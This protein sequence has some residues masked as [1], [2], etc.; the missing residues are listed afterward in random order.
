[1]VRLA[2]FGDVFAAISDPT[3]RE[4]LDRLGGGD[5]TVS[6]LA[7][8]FE[9]SQPAV[10]QH[11]RILRQAG[12]VSQQREGRFRRYRLNAEGLKHVYDWVSHYKRFW[13]KKLTSLGEYLDQQK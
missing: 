9:M 10:S 7:E 12:L 5:L 13:T 1:M 8:P 3:R 6:E 4:I 11:L 2:D